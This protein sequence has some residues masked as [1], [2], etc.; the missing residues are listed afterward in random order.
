MQPESHFERTEKI[1]PLKPETQKALEKLYKPKGKKP[2]VEAGD[3]F[4]KIIVSSPEAPLLSP[5][6]LE[7][8]K[9]V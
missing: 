1:T 9:R 6:E 3:E 8:E 7:E 5:E 4:G 2:R